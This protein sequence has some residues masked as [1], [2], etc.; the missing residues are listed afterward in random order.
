MST[1]NVVAGV[2]FPCRQSNVTESLVP[3]LLASVWMYESLSKVSLYTVGG[4]M[5]RKVHMFGAGRNRQVRRKGSTYAG[6][7]VGVMASHGIPSINWQE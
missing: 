7:G 1:P 2:T 4:Q 3:C 5:P 6:V